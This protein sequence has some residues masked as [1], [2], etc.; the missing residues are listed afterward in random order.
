MKKLKISFDFDSTLSEKPMQDLCRKFMEHAAE[1]WVVT[2]R[3][4]T[5]LGKDVNN[6]DLYAVSDS[7][8]IPRCRLR[9]TAY[10]DKYTI[11]KDFDM[12][13]DDSETEIFHINRVPGRCI[14]F[15]Y[16]AKYGDSGMMD[17]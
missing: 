6:D 7:L 11:V 2:S 16:E 8:N 1:V 9:F 13:S 14:G 12:L 15:L 3:S 4:M 17:F 10:E 5:V